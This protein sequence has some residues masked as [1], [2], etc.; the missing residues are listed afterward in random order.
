MISCRQEPGSHPLAAPSTRGGGRAAR[1][2]RAGGR[3]ALP[4]DDLVRAVARIQPVV[5]PLEEEL[6]PLG[7]AEDRQRGERTAGI[8]GDAGQE[9]AEVTDQ[10]GDGGRG[11]G[12]GVGFARNGQATPA[13]D[14]GR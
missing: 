12:G 1:G 14:R 3:A 6:V 13:R 9:L 5:G 10:A 8:G 2:R 11:G 7:F 4:L